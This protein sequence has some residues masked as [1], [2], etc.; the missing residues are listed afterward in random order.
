MIGHVAECTTIAA[1]T[2]YVQHIH[3]SDCRWFADGLPIHGVTWCGH[4][5]GRHLLRSVYMYLIPEQIMKW[6]MSWCDL[7]NTMMSLFHT[8]PRTLR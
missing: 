7:S 1:V 5:N 3:C 8:H 2:E 4:L 6:P